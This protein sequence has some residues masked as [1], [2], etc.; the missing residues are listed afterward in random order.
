MFI[1]E[2]LKKQELDALSVLN[3]PSNICIDSLNNEYIDC[4]AGLGVANVGHSNSDVI[5]AINQQA[6]R[7]MICHH[8]FPNL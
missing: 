6:S 7:L 5:N 3:D 8:T 1:L 4:V 2:L